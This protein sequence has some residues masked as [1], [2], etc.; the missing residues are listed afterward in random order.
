MPHTGAGGV[1]AL[2]G[3]AL[4]VGAGGVGIRRFATV[5]GKH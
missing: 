4:A 5:R 1:L 2:G 3:M